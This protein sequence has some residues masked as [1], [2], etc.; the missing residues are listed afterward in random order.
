VDW[1]NLAQD[2]GRWL[3]IMNT[4]MDFLITQKGREIIEQLSDFQLL[5]GSAP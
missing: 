4:A 5:K 1:I 2:G 3:V